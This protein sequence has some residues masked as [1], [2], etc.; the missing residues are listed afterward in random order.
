MSSVK[1]MEKCLPVRSAHNSH[2]MCKIKNQ[3][4]YINPMS[5]AKKHRLNRPQSPVS[6][7]PSIIVMMIIITLESY[8][9]HL[10]S[11]FD[12]IFVGC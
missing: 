6:S 4:R 5:C 2:V 12:G 8:F 1:K 11:N 3:N 7:A 10:W 9:G